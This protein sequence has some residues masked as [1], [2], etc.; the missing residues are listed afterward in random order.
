MNVATQ[1][2]PAS[3]VARTPAGDAVTDLVLRTFRLNGAFLEAAE[4]IARPYGLTAASWQVLGAVLDEPLPVVGIARKMGVSR[5][6][7]QRLADLLAER[8]QAT[9]EPNPAHRRAKLLVPTAAGRAAVDDLRGRQHAWAN[10]VGETVDEKELQQA[11]DTLARIGPVVDQLASTR[12][13][14]DER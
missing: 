13:D 1:E 8:G 10:A 11:L 9:Y 7:V 12:R 5:Q 14:G 3:D 4:R 2:H 6:G